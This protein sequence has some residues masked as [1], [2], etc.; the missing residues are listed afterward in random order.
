VVLKLTREW[1]PQTGEMKEEPTFNADIYIF[2][3]FN[4]INHETAD[5]LNLNQWEFFVFTKEQIIEMLGEMKSISLSS[6]K[7]HGIK[8]VHANEL[9]HRVMQLK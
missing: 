8:S 5:P 4:A 1:N 3:Y 9:K 7:R 6:V 2:Y